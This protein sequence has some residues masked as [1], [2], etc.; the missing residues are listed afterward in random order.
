MKDLNSVRWLA[1]IVCVMGP[2]EGF[3]YISGIFCFK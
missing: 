3:K 2:V 1:F